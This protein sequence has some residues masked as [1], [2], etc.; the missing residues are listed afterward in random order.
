[1]NQKVIR[2]GLHSLAVVI[3]ASFVHAL[4]VKSRDTV[5]VNTDISKGSVTVHFKGITQLRL[6]SSQS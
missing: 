4:G 1:M 3:P 5:K 2:S 6:P